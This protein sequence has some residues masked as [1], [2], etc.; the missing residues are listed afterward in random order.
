M[1]SSSF[2]ERNSHL[3]QF[4]CLNLRYHGDYFDG[5]WIYELSNLFNSSGARISPINT[6]CHS[7][8]TRAIIKGRGICFSH[9]IKP[10]SAYSRQ[11]S[12]LK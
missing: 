2:S 8:I 9:M 11:D 3:G 6:I 5:W 12:E 4:I 7:F 10:K 1:I